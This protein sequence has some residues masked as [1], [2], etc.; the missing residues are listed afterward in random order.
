MHVKLSA[1]HLY[2][3]PPPPPPKKKKKKKTIIFFLKNIM[4]H[5]RW[6]YNIAF[7]A[8]C[9]IICWMYYLK[10][11][12][13]RSIS[14][15]FVSNILKDFRNAPFTFTVS[16]TCLIWGCSFIILHLLTHH[17]PW[18]AILSILSRCS[19]WRNTDQQLSSD[20]CEFNW[21]WKQTLWAASHMS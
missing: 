14:T 9:T 10:V 13:D 21:I 1:V 7:N 18:F 2:Q 11:F 12:F 8:N 19:F 17:G 4:I 15:N 5:L 6:R 16:S 3:S 20:K